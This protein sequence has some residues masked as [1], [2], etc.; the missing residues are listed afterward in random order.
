MILYLSTERSFQKAWLLGAKLRQSIRTNSQLPSTWEISVMAAFW[1]HP[2]YLAACPAA[3]APA[4]QSYSGPLNMHLGF[5]F[6]WFW[7]ISSIFK[8][9]FYSLGQTLSSRVLLRLIVTHYY[10]YPS[11]QQ[12]FF[13]FFSC[14]VQLR[15]WHKGDLD[16]E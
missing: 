4:H 6:I 10:S 14:R 11:P 8:S 7:L 13:F 16:K 2:S 1:S 5:P 15:A 12:F 9:V 3:L